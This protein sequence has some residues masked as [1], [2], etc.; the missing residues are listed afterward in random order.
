MSS[1]NEESN[2]P[3][4]KPRNG[5]APSKGTPLTVYVS[6]DREHL[7]E[8]LQEYLGS[9]DI[10]TVVGRAIGI[11]YDMVQIVNSDDMLIREQPRSGTRHRI[12]IPH[13]SK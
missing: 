12:T 11:A 4:N 8:S 3:S 13:G 5:E 9:A 10:H 2:A 7:I 6:R 1:R